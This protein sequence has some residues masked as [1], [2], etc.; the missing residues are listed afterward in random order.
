M[1]VSIG[2]IVGVLII[3]YEAFRGLIEEA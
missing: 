3:A 2:I 1:I